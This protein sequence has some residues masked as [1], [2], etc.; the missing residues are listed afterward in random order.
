MKNKLLKETR[1][2]VAIFLVI[3]LVPMMTV[4]CL[5][6]DISRV[7]L[8]KAL[9]DSAGDLT[10]NSAL[11]QYDSL[12]QEYY[13]LFATSQTIDET[14]AKMDEYFIKC[15]KSAGLSD[16]DAQL[17]SKKLIGS[18]TSGSDESITDFLNII[19]N[20]ADFEMKRTPGGSICNPTLLKSQIVNFMKYRAPINGGLSLIS[21]LKS[22]SNLSKETEL[23]DKRKEYYEAEEKVNT[24]SSSHGLAFPCAVLV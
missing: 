1:G 19:V 4:S 6:V 14:L 5:F 10:L 13:G 3:I 8:A 9:V 24:E 11:T 21:S 16:D 22:F 18:F 15:I 2:A 20:P 17:Y 7:K 23:I 12:L